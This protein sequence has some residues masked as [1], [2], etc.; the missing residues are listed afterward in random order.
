MPLPGGLIRYFGD[1]ELL[2]EIARGGM[3]VVYKARQVS[4][5]RPVALKLILAGQ[6]A[7][8]ED[9]RRFRT[10]SE[11]AANLDHPNIVPI[12]E[13]GEHEGHHFYSMKLIE[14]GRLTQFVRDRQSSINQK[15]AAQ[16]IAIVARAVHYAHQRG[17]LHRDL[18]PGN[19][20]LEKRSGDVTTLV[21]YVTDFGLAKRFEGDARLT[22]S[23]AIVGTPGYMA[24]EQ[25]RGEKG[26]SVAADVYSLGAILY[27]LLTGRPPFQAAT[28][29]DTILQV[30]DNDP[31]RPRSIAPSVNGD[32]ETICLKSLKKDPKRRYESAAELAA[33]LERWL[34][35][36][37]IEARPAGK[38]ERIV[39]WARR[40][41][42]AAALL[43][44]STVAL[45]AVVG[46]GT[47]FTLSLLEQVDATRRARNDADDKA[48]R[49]T[50]QVQETEQAR[51]DADD[52]AGKL[53]E[54][55]LELTTKSD[56]L[57]SALRQ[58][59]RLLTDTRIQLIASALRDGQTVL[60]RD[61]LDEVPAQ[62][63][64]WDWHYLKQEQEGSLFT[65][66]GHEKVEA[67]KLVG[68]RAGVDAVAF[69]PDGATI[70]S[71]G[72]DYNGTVKVW[73]AR[74]G[75]ER[76][77]L[78]GPKNFGRR[79]GGVPEI[80]TV[81]YSPDGSRL[82]GTG[83]VWDAR[84]GEELLTVDMAEYAAFSPDG[85]RVA[86]NYRYETKIWDARTCKELLTIKGIY[87]PMAFSAD[88]AR[89][90][91]NNGLVTWDARTGQ[92]LLDLKLTIPPPHQQQQF[93]DFAL[94]PDGNSLAAYGKVCNAN[95]G[96]E[97]FSTNAVSGKAAYSPDSSRLA[98]INEDNSVKLWDARIGQELFTLKGHTFP[99]RCVAFSPDGARLASAS[100]SNMQFGQG[101]YV[102]PG[103]VKVWDARTGQQ[104][105]ALNGH[106]GGVSSLAFS[107]DGARLATGSEDGTVKVWDAR[108][109][110]SP[111]AHSWASNHVNCV[112][113]SPDG[114]RLAGACGVPNTPN[115]GDLKVWDAGTGKELLSLKGHTRPVSSVAYSPDG[116]RLAS[117]ATDGFQHNEPPVE[118]KIW[119]AHTG[120]E[121]LSLAWN[122]R[123]PNGMMRSLCFSPDGSRLAA[124]GTETKVW[125][126]H[127]GKE[128]FAIKG[129]ASSVAFSPDGT[130]LALNG[131]IWDARTGQELFTLNGG[132]MWSVSFS[133]D[134]SRLVGCGLDN[135]DLHLPGE[136]K[137]WDA[138]TGQELLTLKGHSSGVLAVTF[139]PDGARLV[140]GSRDQSI[141][142]WDA[143]TGQ[144]LFTLK[145]HAPTVTSVAFNSDG[146][147]L[148][149]GSCWDSSPGSRGEI[150]VWDLRPAQECFVFKGDK[151]PWQKVAFSPNGSRLA[152][153]GLANANA[154]CVWDTGTGLKTVMEED[155][156][157]TDPLMGPFIMGPFN[158][159]AFSPDS[160]RL[161]A[162]GNRSV[163]WDA[164]TGKEI[165]THKR[166][167]G[168]AAYSPDGAQLVSLYSNDIRILNADTGQELLTLANG[169]FQN[170]KAISYNTDGTSVVLSFFDGSVLSF[171]ARTGK[172]QP[173]AAKFPAQKDPALSPD[174]RYF[175]KTDHTN[176]RLIDLRLSEEELLFRQRVTSTD[177]DWHDAEAQRFAQAGD[178]FAAAFHLRQ[179]IQ[180]LPNEFSCY[181]DLALCQIAAGQTE[182]H[183]RTCAT[184]VAKLK[185]LAI[186]LAVLNLST[187]DIVQTIPTWFLAQHVDASCKPSILRAIVLSPGA[188]DKA[189]L[190]WLADGLDAVNRC[191]AL[192]RLG[193]HDE[194]AKIVVDLKTEPR[195]L[196][197]HALAEKA[198][199]HSAEAKSS[200]DQ[201]CQVLKSLNKA[202]ALPWQE[203]VE[204][205]VLRLE[206]E[207]ALGSP[208]NEKSN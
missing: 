72:W 48:G 89:L 52:K 76:F 15:D 157:I 114:A 179:R 142:I 62:E 43:V 55:A 81:T 59:N 189:E 82:V 4:L 79:T 172:Q 49:L 120:K 129:V 176:I 31:I 50:I 37:A 53:R 8:P 110:Q 200:Y 56:D 11:A 162:C 207:K 170:G 40:R 121:L 98:T 70:A 90:F 128:L 177:P 60:A 203:R 196:L 103:E 33:D 84:T 94:S 27:E 14:G 204:V 190:S 83:K 44:V 175:A 92:R 127:T 149:S 58:S 163:Q 57:D 173:E 118:T 137:V 10:E 105:L 182:A 39:R 165:F 147:R 111:R 99:V 22:R 123:A 106:T 160:R 69:S 138:R 16:L 47:A 133:R 150:T 135:K 119:D 174:G 168:R 68:Q 199:G 167:Y 122:E 131:I 1:Y 112:A 18:K 93:G 51:K 12:Y 6:F 186:A 185:G 158:T 194:A 108:P 116:T 96:Q 32:L 151:V 143:N 23:G 197:F 153:Y 109:H 73:D 20:L 144:E 166:S 100:M 184:A 115:P 63:R 42:A 102:Y 24:P 21:P 198:Q 146:T 113:F 7:S 159:L 77:T 25:A 87:G 164:R 35:G 192:H 130:R 152:S 181:R 46:G 2:E 180:A 126:A 117:A 30:L 88:G 191:A 26:L 19:V 178:W 195:A 148:A 78:K 156:S 136:I 85:T 13:V 36:E 134:G 97:L 17:I 205:D 95:S 202:T 132:K 67:V 145:S 169:N 54:T 38:V 65:L 107:P 61:R 64:F 45:V 9:V 29:L 124:T 193:K 34:Q 140:S 86:F 139:S 201:A 101:R 154:V 187:R 75:R 71:C 141:K 80:M 208:S 125:N 74:T 161:L 171:D 104:L 28:P 66:F 188:V 91:T 206:L 5:N 3:G 183:K 155:A 41:P